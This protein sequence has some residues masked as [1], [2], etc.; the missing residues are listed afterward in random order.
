MERHVNNGTETLQVLREIM[1]SI[2]F[3]LFIVGKGSYGGSV[4][5][6]GLSDWEECPE[7]GPVGDL[8]ASSDLDIKSS[9]LIIQQHRRY[10]NNNNEDSVQG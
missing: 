4:M 3:S 8:L 7:L 10:T 1:D 2:E 6:T 9:V 5:T